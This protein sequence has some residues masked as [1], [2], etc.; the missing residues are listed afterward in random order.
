MYVHAHKCVRT[1]KFTPIKYSHRRGGTGCRGNGLARYKVPCT[2]L[3]RRS[4]SLG[5]FFVTNRR[6]VSFVWESRYGIS[7]MRIHIFLSLLLAKVYRGIDATS[8]SCGTSLARARNLSKITAHAR[9]NNIFR[10]IILQLDMGLY[11]YAQLFCEA[12]IFPFILKKKEQKVTKIVRNCRSS[13]ILYG[14]YLMY[15]QYL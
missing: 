9:V 8:I 13:E 5:D 4:S 6:R 11:K 2:F 7:S 14:F 12:H 1:Y 3:C 15:K 10:K